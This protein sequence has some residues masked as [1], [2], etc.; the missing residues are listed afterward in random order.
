MLLRSRFFILP[1]SAII[2][3]LSSSVVLAQN[4]APVPTTFDII[5]PADGNAASLINHDYGTS[6]GKNSR[7]FYGGDFFYR[8]GDSNNKGFKGY[9]GASLA[10]GTRKAYG[11]P[12]G[13][14]LT[15]GGTE[16]GSDPAYPTEGFAYVTNLPITN[17][18]WDI[19]YFDPDDYGN[20]GTWLVYTGCNGFIA[21]NEGDTLEI[22]ITGFVDPNNQLVTGNST[23]NGD[24]TGKGMKSQDGDGNPGFDGSNDIT[25]TIDAAY[26]PEGAYF[27]GTRLVWVPSFIQGDGAQDNSVRN[28]IRFIDANISN[29]STTSETVGDTATSGSHIGYGRGE[30]RDSLYVIYFRAT[31]DSNQEN[32]TAVDSLFILVNDSLLNPAPLFTRRT[33]LRIDST[34]AQETRTFDYLANQPDTLFSVFEGD[35]VVITL[36]AVDTDSVY[37]ETNDALAIGMLWSDSLLNVDKNG[38]TTDAIA[39]FNQY[40]SRKG[41]ADTLVF[42]T[43][44]TVSGGS[45]TSF[46]I[47]L[48][49]PYNL[50]T[51]GE[52]ADTLVVMVSDGSS[53][54]ADTFALKVRNTNRAPIW[55][56]DT[57]SLPP[58]SALIYSSYADLVQ[59]DSID[60]ITA[61]SLNNNQTDSTYFASYVFD[62][63][64]LVG[65]Q[66][67]ATLS[68]SYSG[69][70]QGT[71]NATTGL[72]V[73]TPVETDTVTYTFTITA[74]DDD[75]SDSKSTAQEIIFR[76]APAP[77]ITKV[78]PAI[79]GINQEFTITGSGFGLYDEGASDTSKVIFYATSGGRRQ[80]IAANIISWS[81][82]RV[83]ATV[84]SGVPNSPKDATL[85]YLLPDTIKLVSAIYGGFDTYPFV[86]I[87]DSTGYENLDVVNI[88]SSA[89]TIRYRTDF[90]GADSV[91]VASSSDTLDIHSSAF[92]DAA[93]F[94]R[95]PTFVDYNNGLS[96]I[97]STV[98]VYQDQSTSTDGI[99]II[100]LDNLSPGTVYQFFIGSAAGYF[101]ADSLRNINGPY[102]PKKIDRN[103]RAN[104]NY[105]DAF[106]FRTLPRT[107]S[108]GTLYTLNGKAYYSGG[109]ATNAAITVR[110]VSGTNPADT[111]LPITTVVN[112]DSTWEVNLANLNSTGGGS[113]AHAAGDTI[114]IEVDGAEKG[115]EQLV[116]ARGANNESPQSVPAFKIVPYVKYDL[117]LLTGL[118]LIGIPLSLN[119]YQPSTADELMALIAGGTPSVTRYITSTG[120]QETRSR[121][122]SGTYVGAEDFELLTGEAYFVEVDGKSTPQ[123]IGRVY[124]EELSTITFP[125]AGLYFVSRPSQDASLFYSWDAQQILQTLDS[126]SIVIRW[127]ASKQQYEQSLLAG[128]NFVGTNFGIDPGRGYIFN[129]TGASSWNPNG[130]SALLAGSADNSG[131]SGTEQVIVLDVSQEEQSSSSALMSVSNVTS[132]AAV[133]TW[134]SG[135]SD[136]GRV[137][138]SRADGSGEQVYSPSVAGVSDNLSSVLITGLEPETEYRFRVETSGAQPLDGLSP[139]TFTTSRIGIGMRPY[140][141]YSQLVDRDGG[142][143]PGMLVLLRLTGKVS[144]E[145]SRYLSAFSDRNGYWLLNLANLKT[146]GTG[147]PFEWSEGDRIELSIL[148]AG[149][150]SEFRAEVQPGSP[151]NIAAD[152]ELDL[153]DQNALDK[154]ARVSLPKAYALSQNYPNP[155]NPST[156]IQFAVPEQ[157]SPVSVRLEVYN[158]RGALVRT[159]VDGV[160]EP[161]NYSIQWQGKDRLGRPVSSGVYFY[162]LSTPNFKAVRKMVLLK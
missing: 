110:V 57:S 56:A 155:F 89:A 102:R 132:S 156:T 157:E 67:G 150:R 8:D 134:S 92:E 140:T 95:L 76:V 75:P 36:Y 121:S 49:L 142:V 93:K 34:G 101:A 33:M 138:L 47:R 13:S 130:P 124:T 106:R 32:N 151:H 44:S 100:N 162:R 7:I 103:T 115:F 149:F 45:V 42:D 96:E 83:V 85:S 146:A 160:R 20:A 158:L 60:A 78:E 99:H 16:Y 55:D 114:L 133:V 125:G 77:S 118:N 122:V 153:P 108:T 37:G 72:N 141:L 127:N 147:E 39:G 59:H 120:T 70:H 104:N 38:D 123:L 18:D 145:Q 90:S 43:T 105:L 161:G 52:K 139:G 107:S 81:Q 26:L 69:N 4:T 3:M 109:A 61:F 82:D 40:I 136:P 17:D 24:Y 22:N 28:G 73:F 10:A 152:L 6:S 46:R 54:A 129:V 66:V 1:I 11:N 154:P 31:D 64:N 119:W 159:L 137:R 63:E 12:T 143:L 94:N 116:V 128:G 50:A 21:I 71:L 65:D 29:G 84:P 2:L 48:R 14:R 113:F 27:D 135:G 9:T 30:L 111:S 97:R 86:V 98:V 35:S 25:F 68:F 144:G 131:Q 51:S 80:D 79:G 112:S 53:I 15:L 23:A 91:V 87:T 117:E 19:S 62:P 88:T 41:T 74:A 5:S 148:S 126:V 58:D